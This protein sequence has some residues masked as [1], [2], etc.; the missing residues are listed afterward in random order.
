[1]DSVDIAVMPSLAVERLIR[2]KGG[3]VGAPYEGPRPTHLEAAE[4]LLNPRWSLQRS[5]LRWLRQP[6]ADHLTADSRAA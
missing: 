1:M 4:R 6:V 5:L 2:L 3:S